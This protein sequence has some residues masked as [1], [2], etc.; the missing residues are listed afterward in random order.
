MLQVPYFQQNRDYTCGPVCLRM[1]LAYWGYEAD[2]VSLSMLCGTTVFGTSAKQLASA[3]QRLGFKCEYWFKGRYSSLS[4]ALRSIIPPIVSVNASTL[5]QLSETLFV[6]HDIVLLEIKPR[7]IVYHDP[8]VGSNLSAPPD[9][10]KE[11]WQQ[12]KNEVILI[13][14]SEKTFIPK[15]KK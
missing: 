9:I 5:Y 8:E 11:A 3:A 6:K 13:W 15:S 10:F 14:P 4:H 1:V 7:V 2:E 12:A